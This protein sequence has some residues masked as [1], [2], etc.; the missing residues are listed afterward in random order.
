MNLFIP[1]VNPSY[2]TARE[3]DQILKGF[4][5]PLDHAEGWQGETCDKVRW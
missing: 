2:F 5:H 1:P 4:P 3:M